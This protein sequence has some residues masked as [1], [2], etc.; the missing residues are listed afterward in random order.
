MVKHGMRWSLGRQGPEDPCRRGLAQPRLAGIFR[1]ALQ[2]LGLSSTSSTTP[3]YVLYQISKACNS[4]Y[5][6]ALLPTSVSQ[7][8]TFTAC[9]QPLDQQTYQPPSPLHARCAGGS[10]S[11]C[12]RLQRMLSC[13][14]YGPFLLLVMLMRCTC[15]W[16]CWCTPWCQQPLP[17][18]RPPPLLLLCL[19]GC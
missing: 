13:F 16:L 15:C 4:R 5:N 18:G 12:L 9:T 14:F 17:L 1:M 8:G 2:H 19:A 3:S 11:I 10:T 6:T 7:S